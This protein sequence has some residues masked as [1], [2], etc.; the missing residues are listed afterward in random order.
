MFL[1]V[2]S[3]FRWKKT[4][5]LLLCQSSVKTSLKKNR[6]MLRYAEL[7]SQLLFPSARWSSKSTTPR[8]LSVVRNLRIGLAHLLALAPLGTSKNPLKGHLNPPSSCHVSLYKRP[9]LADESGGLA[10]YLRKAN[11]FFLLK[12]ACKASSKIE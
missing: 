8:N 2:F 7:P 3:N 6:A 4:C 11:Q 12:A 9:H 1:P 10:K 5:H